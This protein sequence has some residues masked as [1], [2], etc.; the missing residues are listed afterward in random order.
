MYLDRKAQRNPT[1]TKITNR[2]S[3]FFQELLSANMLKGDF[4]EQVTKMNRWGNGLLFY[5][6]MVPLNLCVLPVA[7]Y[8]GF[9]G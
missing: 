9:P 5:T 2:N 1:K 8:A 6:V 7:M 4:E 3:R